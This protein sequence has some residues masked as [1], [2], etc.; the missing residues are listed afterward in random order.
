MAFNVLSIFPNYLL[1][2]ILLDCV[3]EKILCRG[4]RF[5]ND[6]SKIWPTLLLWLLVP[7]HEKLY[8][9]TSKEKYL[10][11]RLYDREQGQTGQE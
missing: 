2:W 8:K 5:I 7:L 10:V 4:G 9:T 1:S 6:H 11:N 3:S